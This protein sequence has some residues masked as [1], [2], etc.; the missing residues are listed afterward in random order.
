MKLSILIPQL[1]TFLQQ[2]NDCDVY[3]QVTGNSQVNSM[4]AISDKN[5][6]VKVVKLSDV[7]IT[8]NTD[9]QQTRLSLIEE[10]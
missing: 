1:Q 9:Y 5:G 3:L 7:L 2:H 4:L 8:P 10:N 6:T